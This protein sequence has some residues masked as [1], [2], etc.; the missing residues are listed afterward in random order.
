M[1]KFKLL[2]SRFILL[3]VFPSVK[4]FILR[5]SSYILYTCIMSIKLNANIFHKAVFIQNAKYN[6]L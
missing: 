4:V 2:S 6:K 5:I 1:I 3:H